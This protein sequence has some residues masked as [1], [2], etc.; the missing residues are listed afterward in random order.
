M[1]N[2]SLARLT[3]AIKIASTPKAPTTANTASSTSVATSSQAVKP[4]STIP[5]I[6]AAMITASIERLPCCDQ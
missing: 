5:V 2:F 4:T 6:V 1:P 3:R